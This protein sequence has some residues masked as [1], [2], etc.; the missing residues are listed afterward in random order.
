MQDGSRA[1]PVLV[2]YG[3]TTVGQPVLLAI[4]PG[5]DESHD[6]WADFLEDL[7]ARGLRPP[8]LVISDGAPG[9]IGAVEVKMSGSV[10]CAAVRASFSTDRCPRIGRVRQ[11][12]PYDD[13]TV[14][15]MST[16]L[17]CWCGTPIHLASAIVALGSTLGLV[18]D[19]A[20]QE[21]GK[22]VARVEQT[23]MMMSVRHLGRSRWG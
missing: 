3:I 5:G 1:E 20:E 22:V 10:R 18:A 4:E 8:L 16:F 6:A 21:P 15:A 14:S 2:A 17:A 12:R 11:S 7:R 9:L 23:A 13:P 19:R